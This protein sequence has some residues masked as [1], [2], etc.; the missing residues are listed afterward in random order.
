MQTCVKCGEKVRNKDAITW[1]EGPVHT[2]ICPECYAEENDYCED[3]N[4]DENKPHWMIV[5]YESA[6]CS[7]CGGMQYMGWDSTKEAKEKIKTLHETYKYC[8][9]CGVK[10]S[11]K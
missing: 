1:E 3:Q 8:P 4:G 9:F 5:E 10:M 7:E 2:Y 11:R 6:T